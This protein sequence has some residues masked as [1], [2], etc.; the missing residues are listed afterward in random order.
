MKKYFLFLFL[1]LF[2]LF[3]TF[4]S[5]DEYYFALPDGH[6]FKEAALDKEVEGGVELRFGER[7]E[8]VY[9]LNRDDTVWYRAS[10][11]GSQFY[12]PEPFIVR[13]KMCTHYDDTGIQAHGGQVFPAT[14]HSRGEVQPHHRL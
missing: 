14:H 10:K 3:P 5:G 1:C 4:S 7:V 12:I 11:D 6:P 2:F 13:I 9:K 8:I